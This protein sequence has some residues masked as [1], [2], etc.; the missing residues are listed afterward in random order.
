MSKQGTDMSKDNEEKSVEEVGSIFR[1]EAIQSSISSEDTRTPFNPVS[2]Y[3][4]VVY[5]AYALFAASLLT[6]LFA[7][8]IP[9]TIEGRAIAMKPQGLFS[10]VA[11][12]NGIVKEILVSPGQSIH[13]GQVLMRLEDPEK[14]KLYISTLDKFQSL[15]KDVHKLH[16]EIE[17]ELKVQKESIQQQII[18]T[19]AAIKESEANII[20]LEKN[21]SSK[22]KLFQEKLIGLQQ[23]Y[24]ATQLLSNRQIELAKT[25]GVL[26]TY[27]SNLTKSY[28]QQELIGK[29]H[30][31]LDTQQELELL[32]NSLD[33]LN[34]VSNGDGV[35]LEVSA[36]MSDRILTGTPLIRVE[37]TANGEKDAYIFYAFIPTVTGKSVQI[38]TKVQIQLSI[39]RAEE[40]GAIIGKVTYIS[41]YPVSSEA[42]GNMIQNAGLVEFLVDG[43]STVM[44]I[45]ITPE[46]NPE[47]PS[48][49]RW[50]SGLGPPIELSVGTVGTV[51][52]LAT[53]I[54]P[55]YYLIALWRLEKLGWE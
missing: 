25:R 23:L 39:A 19:E 14:E 42:I 51:K 38:D 15:T 12:A 1:Q 26:A 20:Q 13:K 28:R 6:W 10:V 4:S 34:I 49:Y 32:K 27:E 53:E 33:N 45:V 31:L 16:M 2:Y 47:S 54:T 18:A 52:G 17:N 9:I 37:S 11:K 22:E 36:N 48:G 29:E 5:F 50:T 7:G 21:L 24:E 46:L 43:N 55:L 41:P 40:Y 30:D 3:P 8:S 44:Q 35:V